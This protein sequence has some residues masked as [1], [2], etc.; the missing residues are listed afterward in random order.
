MKVSLFLLISYSAFSVEF[1]YGLSPEG[2]SKVM[3]IFSRC[4][5]RFWSELYSTSRAREPSENQQVRMNGKSPAL[6]DEYLYFTE[7]IRVYNGNDV[8][9]FFKTSCFLS[10]QS[11]LFKFR[12]GF[13]E[14][15]FIFSHSNWIATRDFE[16]SKNW[17]IISPLTSKELSV[18][19]RETLQLTFSTI[20]IST[21]AFKGL[22]FTSADLFSSTIYLDKSTLDW[23]VLGRVIVDSICVSLL[24]SFAFAFFPKTNPFFGATVVGL[25]EDLKTGFSSAV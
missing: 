21:G 15:R 14:L 8:S 12:W 10:I 11:Y 18:P 24:L 3:T 5:N 25:D 4:G 23:F 13:I 9:K 6:V 7:G 19:S 20:S 16:G 17:S 2:N 1:T 22:T